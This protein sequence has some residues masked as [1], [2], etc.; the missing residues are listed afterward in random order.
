MIMKLKYKVN[1]A[2]QAL[3]LSVLKYKVNFKKFKRNLNCILPV[4]QKK[5]N[6]TKLEGLHIDF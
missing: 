5:K 3:V 6:H 4:N 1:L 2:L